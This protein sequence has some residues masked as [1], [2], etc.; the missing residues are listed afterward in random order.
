MSAFPRGAAALVGTA[1]YGLG[2]SPGL[3]SIDMAVHASVRALSA[4][5]LAPADVDGLFICLADDPLS[6]L[7]LA[8]Y[9]GVQPK[10]LDN[11]RLGGSSFQMHL[12]WATLALAA[13]QC[14][15]ALIAYGSNQK[16]ATGKLMTAAGLSGYESPYKALAPISSYA[17]AVARH[18]HE[19]GTT[20]KHLAEVAVAARSWAKLNPEAV[21][22][23]DLSIDDC[24]NA[25]LVSSPLGLR[26]CC[27]V[28]DGAA[29]AVVVRAERARDLCRY[30]AYVL[31]AASSVT[32]RDISSMPDL[33][34][35]AAVQSAARAYAQ[36][37]I[38]V[39]D[40]D[41]VQLYDAFTINTIMLLED[42]GFCAK[43][44]GGAFVSGGRIAPGGELPV[45]T[46]GGGLSCVHPGMYGLFTLVEAARQIG[47]EC[48]A[49]Q[50]PDVNI[51]LAH[52]NG[53]V[54]SSQATVVLCSAAAL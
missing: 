10:V 1:T 16:T 15:V 11:S 41:V 8:E 25:R 12:F 43:G 52:G 50:V 20:R 4:C 5:G 21:M 24:L 38:G 37:G 36:A 47:G 28:T 42:L 31:G 51:A 27:L 29:A 49:R 53:G 33:T 32:H 9:L 48:G 13:G 30:P 19:F 40:V 3:S 35:T 34:T 17:L 44:E 2:E 39:G 26:D 18:M 7:T 45:N 14:D 46:N 22:R 54:L 6:G 23:A